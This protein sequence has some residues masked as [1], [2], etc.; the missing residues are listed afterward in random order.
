[1]EITKKRLLKKTDWEFHDGQ[2]GQAL[3]TYIA[4]GIGHINRDNCLSF[5][6]YDRD[7][8]KEKFDSYQEW[9]ENTHKYNLTTHELNEYFKANK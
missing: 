5:I 9:V 2:A 8:V 4:K 7:L 6:D 1:M 3:W